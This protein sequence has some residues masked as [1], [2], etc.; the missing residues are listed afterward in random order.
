MKDVP[1]LIKLFKLTSGNPFTFDTLLK[2]HRQ[3]GFKNENQLRQWARRKLY[4]SLLKSFSSE[5]IPEPLY[6]WN[7]SP[8]LAL[9]LIEKNV[10]DKKLQKWRKAV[11]P[12][13]SPRSREFLRQKIS[14]YGQ[15]NSEI[16]TATNEVNDLKKK[17]AEA[18]DNREALIKEVRDF[19]LPFD[20]YEYLLHEIE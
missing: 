5:Q 12:P 3:L 17:L 18:I 9:K 7:C 20:F 1:I 10:P 19:E 15:K 6:Y 14:E 4:S 11:Q 2:L 8:G 13:L 16:V